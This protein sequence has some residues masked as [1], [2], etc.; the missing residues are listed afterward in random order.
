[1]QLSD[2]GAPDYR[3]SCNN[4]NLYVS[5]RAQQNGSCHEDRNGEIASSRRSRYGTR[6]LRAAL[7]ATGRPGC[8]GAGITGGVADPGNRPAAIGLYRSVAVLMRSNVTQEWAGRSSG[9][10]RRPCRAAGT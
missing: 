5:L 10:A 7:R 3:H 1:M 6:L 2:A 8:P 4:H 9:S